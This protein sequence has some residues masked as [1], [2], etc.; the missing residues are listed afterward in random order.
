MISLHRDIQRLS[1]SMAEASAGQVA[2]IVAAIDQMAVRGPAD[3]LIAPLRPRLSALGIER[4][5][6]L[7]RLSFEPLD[8]LIVDGRRWK[9]GLPLIPRTALAPLFGVI[10]P[11]LTADHD[12]LREAA[13]SRTARHQLS[14]RVWHEAAAS[15]ENAEIPGDWRE[16]T[17]L[18]DSDFVSIRGIVIGLLAQAE[19]L[20]NLDSSNGELHLAE[21]MRIIL[22][23]AAEL[24]GMAWQAMQVH[25]YQ[26]RDFA[27][28][29]QRLAHELAVTPE[30]AQGLEPALACARD[31][32]RD[33][34]FAL[35]DSGRLTPS[36]LSGMAGIVIDLS[37]DAGARSQRK[38]AAEELRQQADNV[39]D[40]AMARVIAQDLLPALS[41]RDEKSATQVQRDAEAAAR[42]ARSFALIGSGLGASEKYDAQMRPIIERLMDPASSLDRADRARLLE[43]LGNSTLALEL[44]K[45]RS[46]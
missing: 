17:G 16:A 23:A 38:R 39:C 2:Q 18:P 26:D 41:A 19:R 45:T 11:G 6:S 24:G 43:L 32:L 44:L 21:A 30:L 10:G 13:S 22:G 5:L 25:L 27:T 1:G 46:A 28:L 31:L 36:D 4:P 34:L 3:A 42:A 35:H 8:R 29:A 20:A 7:C 33:R 9:R 14:S 37:A 15:I 12:L 40:Q